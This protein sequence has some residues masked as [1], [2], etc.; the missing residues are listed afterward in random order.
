MR[1]VIPLR[2][3]WQSRERGRYKSTKEINAEHNS[4]EYIDDEAIVRLMSDTVCYVSKSFVVFNHFGI[5]NNWSN[6]DFVFRDQEKGFTVYPSRPIFVF[7]AMKKY[8]YALLL[9]GVPS[10]L[11]DHLISTWNLVAKLN[12]CPEIYSTKSSGSEDEIS[13]K[14]K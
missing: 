14:F 4:D 5:P 7:T 2:K 10:F 8:R 1:A 9:F 12:V 3:T 6:Y 13:S 11:R